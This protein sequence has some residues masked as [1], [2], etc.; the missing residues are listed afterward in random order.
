MSAQVS[1][2]ISVCMLLNFAVNSI[3]ATKQQ[4][5]KPTKRFEHITTA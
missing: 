4:N 2:I 1:T 3:I 5:Q